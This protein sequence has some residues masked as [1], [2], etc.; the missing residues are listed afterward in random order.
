MNVTENFIAII[1]HTYSFK[2]HITD[3]WTNFFKIKNNN[4][5]LAWTIGLYT[6]T[7]V[8]TGAPKIKTQTHLVIHCLKHMSTDVPRNIPPTFDP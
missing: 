1:L 2:K 5:P 7:I 8:G 6:Q 3:T 4:S